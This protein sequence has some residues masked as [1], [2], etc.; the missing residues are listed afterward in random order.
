MASR[1]QFSREAEKGAAQVKATARTI[2]AA[3]AATTLFVAVGAM[4]RA[5]TTTPLSVAA[6]APAF[7]QSSQPVGPASPFSGY[8][9]EACLDRASVA[10]APNLGAL[11][12]A[13]RVRIIYQTPALAARY[14]ALSAKCDYSNGGKE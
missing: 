12:H 10:A 7:A 5:R 14:D 4:P 6:S 3:L 2:I 13:S 8:S 9:E 11:D 1:K